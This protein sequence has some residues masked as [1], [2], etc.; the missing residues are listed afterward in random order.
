MNIVCVK[1]LFFSEG[2]A[3]RYRE[4]GSRPGRTAPSPLIWKGALVLS[5]Q[6]VS[7][8]MYSQRTAGLM[9]PIVCPPRMLKSAPL[10]H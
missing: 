8:L 9:E 1:P 4:G 6:V 5:S 7:I 2:D 3:R 10:L